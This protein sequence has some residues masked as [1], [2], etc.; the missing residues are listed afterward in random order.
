V[1]ITTYT[2]VTALPIVMEEIAPPDCELCFKN[3][4]PSKLYYD[5]DIICT[6][7]VEG[8]MTVNARI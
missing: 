7:I 1:D 6:G 2:F 5:S 3:T 8:S 4:A